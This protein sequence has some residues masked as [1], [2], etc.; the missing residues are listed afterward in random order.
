MTKIQII[1][2]TLNKNWLTKPI[3]TYP[4]VSICKNVRNGQSNKNKILWKQ[5]S[6][7]FCYRNAINYLNLRHCFTLQPGW[8]RMHNIKVIALNRKQYELIG[9][10]ASS[11]FITIHFISRILLLR[12]NYFYV[13]IESPKMVNMDANCWIWNQWSFWFS[14]TFC[15][16]RTVCNGF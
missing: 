4:M 2:K 9:S 8:P 5:F 16:W 10:M 11:N 3:H 13:H 6:H 7:N 14:K 12:N 15:K 1:L